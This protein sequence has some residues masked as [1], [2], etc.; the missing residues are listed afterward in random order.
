MLTII[1]DR[2]KAMIKKNMTLAQ[3]QQAHPSLEYDGI[4]GTHK[5]LTG[6]KFLEVAYK[7]LSGKK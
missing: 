6:D 5:D 3:I 4:Y 7:D 1:R 2:V